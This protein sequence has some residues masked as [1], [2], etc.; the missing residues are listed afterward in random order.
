MGETGFPAAAESGA[1]K[2]G[3]PPGGVRR[4]RRPEPDTGLGGER[5]EGRRAVLEAL[6]AGRRRVRAVWMASTLAPSPLLAEIRAEAA[7]RGVPVNVVAPEEVERRAETAAPQGVVARADPLPVADVDALFVAPDA[8]LVALDGVTDPHNV[9]AVLRTAECAGATGAVLPRRRAVHVTP[10]VTK[11][12]AGAVEHLPVALVAGIPTFL[13]RAARAGVWTVGLDPG[14]EVPISDLPV[15]D[16]PVVLVF[17]AE[18]RGLSR[19][20]R[21]RCDVVARIPMQGHLASLNVAAAAAIA[22]YE[23]SRARARPR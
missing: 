12:A 10:A 3:R 7:A 9:G 21:E 15:A 17:G 13:E 19:L 2:S 4:G 11:A 5:I 22:C 14:G 20:A 6:V 16:R 8:F 1:R 18:G 23:V